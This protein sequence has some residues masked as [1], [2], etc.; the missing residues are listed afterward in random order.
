MSSEKSGKTLKV[1]WRT[2]EHFTPLLHFLLY[3]P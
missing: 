2:E 3:Y 1:V